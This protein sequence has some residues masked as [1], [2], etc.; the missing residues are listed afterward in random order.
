[1][2]LNAA[3]VVE[4][5]L[6]P[7]DLLRFL[8][9]VERQFGRI[10]TEP[11]SPRTIDLDLLLAEGCVLSTPELVLPHPRMH[12]RAFVLVPLAEV[13]PDAIHPTSGKTMQALLSLIP[14]RDRDAITLYKKPYLHRV[15]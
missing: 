8:L 15:Y 3:V 6:S 11:N 14:Q 10:R 9:R 7:E 13:A 12:E 2:F 5:D 1:M 4:T